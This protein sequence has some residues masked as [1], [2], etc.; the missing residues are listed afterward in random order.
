[1]INPEA[2]KCMHC[3]SDVS[4]LKEKFFKSQTKLFSS[5]DFFIKDSTG[6]VVLNYESIKDLA[7]ELHREMPK[8]SALSIMVTH[9]SVINKITKGLPELLKKEFQSELEGILKAIKSK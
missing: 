3:G 9:S 8:N 5:E 4:E 2:I 1:M 7:Q 6:E